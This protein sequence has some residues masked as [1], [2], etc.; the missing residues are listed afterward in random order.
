MRVAAEGKL[1]RTLRLA[2]GLLWR[3][4]PLLLTAAVVAL[5]LSQVSV[6]AIARLLAGASLPWLVWGALLLLGSNV[7]RAFRLAALFAARPAAVSRLFGVA[8]ALS[9]FNNALPA[10]SGEVTFL[11]MMRELI[12]VPVGEAGAVL[13]VARIFD[14]LAV[15]TLFVSSALL[16]LSSLRA[17]ALWATLAVAAF[18]LL[19]VAALALL[20]CLGQAVLGWLQ[21]VCELSLAQ[22][23]GR[24][25]LLGPLVRVA[26]SATR[27][28]TIT[29]S[30]PTYGLTA[31]WLLLAW[32]GTFGWFWAFLTATGVHAGPQEVVV[33]AT[34]AVLSKAMP[35]LSIGGFGAHEAG[36]TVG[37]ML[38]GFDKELAIASGFAVNILTMVTSFVFGSVAVLTLFWFRRHRRS[39]SDTAARLV[40]LRTRISSREALAWARRAVISPSSSF[41]WVSSA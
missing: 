39:A 15:A 19:T 18:L 8:C 6:A 36:W 30:L 2:R 4:V 20:P 29:R 22:P 40:C 35:F 27:A 5:L 11:Y 32:S 14:Y 31:L 34:F 1:E 23:N 3:A 13:V 26:E 24:A 10:R 25:V 12:G 16:S 9:M 28:L 38:V 21:R 41:S 7:C 17:Q 33:G 37:F